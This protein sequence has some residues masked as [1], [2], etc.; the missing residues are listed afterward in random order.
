L[1]PNP[2]CSVRKSGGPKPP[3]REG[4]PDADVR[5]G[6]GGYIDM[7]FYLTEGGK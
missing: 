6:D 3:R 4:G 2:E 7:V 5:S 1:V